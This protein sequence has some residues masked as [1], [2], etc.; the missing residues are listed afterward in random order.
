[1]PKKCKVCSGEKYVPC[2]GRPGYVE[3]MF[4]G[5]VYSNDEIEDTVS[6][7]K[8]SIDLINT[9]GK[10]VCEIVWTA[11]NCMYQGTGWYIGN[12]NIITNAHVV[13][14]GQ[15]YLGHKLNCKFTYLGKDAVYIG[16]AEKLDQVNDVAVVKINDDE[17]LRPHAIKLAENPQYTIGQTVYTIGNT[18]GRGLSPQKGMISRLDDMEFSE[19]WKKLNAVPLLRT[20]LNIDHGNSG[21]P[22]INS[23]GE[24]IGLMSSGHVQESEVSIFSQ[25]GRMDNVVGVGSIKVD[26]LSIAVRLICVKN[27]L[28]SKEI[29]KPEP[30]PQVTGPKTEDILR[31]LWTIQTSYLPKFFIEN[32]KEFVYMLQNEEAFYDKLNQLAQSVKLNY[33]FSEGDFQ[34]EPCNNGKSVMILYPD[35]ITNDNLSIVQIFSLQ[36]QKVYGVLP[37]GVL[38]EIKDGQLY[39]IQDVNLSNLESIVNNL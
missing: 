35:M 29:Y 34:I 18:V 6:E 23:K 17:R 12:G 11:D 26:E 15:G 33:E 16:E 8:K 25:T 13:L 38:V 22:L 3:C 31:F 1:M 2:T 19:G 24:A 10:G 21:G 32:L 4:C 5:T 37:V 9:I 36:K 20:T 7:E 14:D 28:N 27:L 39:K 30:R